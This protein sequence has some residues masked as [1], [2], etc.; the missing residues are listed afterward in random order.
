VKTE[1]KLKILKS[2]AKP[3]GFGLIDGI[4]LNGFSEKIEN[5]L[6]LES[7]DIE[8]IESMWNI[9]EEEKALDKKFENGD[10]DVEQ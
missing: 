8:F 2:E 4:L 1:E 3:Y 10:I 7:H 9:M 5:G 6:E